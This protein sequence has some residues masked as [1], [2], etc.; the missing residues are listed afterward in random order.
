VSESYTGGCACGAIRY[1]ISG[2][3]L[4]MNDC[5]CR[6][7]Q[8][9]SG[10]GHGSYLTFLRPSAEVKLRG[11]AALWDIVGD[12]GNVKTRGFCPTCGSPVHLT[13]A[14][15]PELFTVH[16]ASLDDPDRYK[17]QM[18]TYHVRGHAWDHLDPSVPTF[19]KMPPA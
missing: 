14:A 17:P 10:T 12:S 1:E 16:A 6:D 8:R 15:M 11:Q 2:E 9:K 3:P 19:D 5:Q 7:C 13:F 4:A 18:V